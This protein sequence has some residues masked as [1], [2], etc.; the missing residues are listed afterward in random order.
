MEKCMTLTLTFIDCMQIITAHD[1]SENTR[2]TSF[3]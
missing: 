3:D 2:R 1:Q